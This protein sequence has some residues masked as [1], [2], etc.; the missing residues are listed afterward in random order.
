MRSCWRKNDADTGI[1]GRRIEQ[2][3][4]S[5]TDS[6]TSAFDT[7]P[8][9]SVD[10]IDNGNGTLTTTVHGH[11]LPGT[12]VG[13]GEAYLDESIPGF[14]N[15]GAYIRFTSTAQVLAVRGVRLLSPDGSIKDV[16]I[17]DGDVEPINYHITKDSR[18]FTAIGRF[19]GTSRV[20]VA[21]KELGTEQPA[22]PKNAFYTQFSFEAPA[23]DE[24][25]CPFGEIGLQTIPPEC[26]VTRILAR[27]YKR[28]RKCLDSLIKMGRGS[29]FC[30]YRT[31]TASR[32]SSG[33]L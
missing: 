4:V 29:S 9:R 28:N 20:F 18:S 15:S 31:L 12:R 27:A 6:Y 24:V 16:V 21:A 30:A 3:C 22:P 2:S 19:H 1:A 14:E 5:K 33:N 7:L 13:L 17:T 25:L 26:S 8:V 23:G 32:Q 10:T 11:F